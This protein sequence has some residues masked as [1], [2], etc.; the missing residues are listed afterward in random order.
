MLI[1]TALLAVRCRSRAMGEE[2]DEA[3]TAVRHSRSGIGTPSRS[4]PSEADS[5]LVKHVR[6]RIG[7]HEFVLS[8]EVDVEGLQQRIL[9]AV[10]GPAAFVSFRSER[11]GEVSV[12][13][14]GCTPI[15]FEIHDRPDSET[16]EWL[17]LRPVPDIADF[18]P[19]LDLGLG[20]TAHASSGTA[21]NS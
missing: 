7:D 11:I 12:L 20:L 21:A 13:V 6:L 8:T 14:T 16:D 2:P 17:L 5:R 18:F 1:R 3:V 4:R 15:H 10:A 9:D 19:D